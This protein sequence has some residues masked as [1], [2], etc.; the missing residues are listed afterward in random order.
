MFINARSDSSLIR[1]LG[2]FKVLVTLVTLWSFLFSL[3]SCDLAWAIRTPLEPTGVGSNRAGGPGAVIKELNVDTFA[4][5]EY[6]GQVRDSFKANSDKVVIHIQDAHCNYAAQK[7]IAE[8]IDYL[9]KEYGAE[10]INLEGGAQNYDLSIFTNIYDK[11]I[12]D[13]V[14]DYF[15]KEGLVNGA[16]YFAINNPE[17]TTLWGV[18]DNKLY[19]DN[20]NVYRESLKYK[21][22]VDANI[23]T[24]SY[25]INNLKAKIYS[26]DLLELD[27]KYSQY[28]A[29]NLEFKDYLT[30]LVHVAKDKGIDVKSLHNIFL[31]QQ[32]LELESA[33][34]FKSANN[35]RD[36]IID[37]LQKVMSR[38]ELEELVAKT[39]DFKAERLSQKDFYTWLVKKAKSINIDLTNLP[40][41]QKYFVYISTYGVID[42]TKIMEEMNVLEDNIKAAL[43]QNGEQREL[44]KL[45]KTLTLLNNIFNISLTKDDYQYYMDNKESFDVT[46]FTSFINKEAPLYKITAQINQNIAN[47]DQYRESISKF[48]EY[49]FK[50]DNAFL[51]NM[52]FSIGKNIAIV[53][54][55]G[56][57]TENLCDIFRKEK[58]SFISIMPTFKNCDGYECPYFKL[59]SGKEAELVTK[60]YP[61]VAQ[62]SSM[63]ISSML[64]T[65]LGEEVWGVIGVS[66][67]RAAILVREE[68]EKGNNI[69]GIEGKGK[70]IV[71]RIQLTSGEINEVT[72]PREEF[73]R[74]L[75]AEVNI[76]ALLKEAYDSGKVGPIDSQ[77]AGVRTEAA[78]RIRS[79]AEQIG[80]CENADRL[81]AIAD[82]IDGKVPINLVDVNNADFEAHAGGRGIHINR[83][84]IDAISDKEARKEKVIELIV[85]EAIAGIGGAHI[86]A[87]LAGKGKLNEAANLLKN[88]DV[89]LQE[90]AMWELNQEARI[91][92][93]NRDYTANG[94]VTLLGVPIVEFVQTKQCKALF[95]AYFLSINE[96]VQARNILKLSGPIT[97]SFLVNDLHVSDGA[98]LEQLVGNVE[99][100]AMNGQDVA[101]KLREAEMMANSLGKKD[102]DKAAGSILEFISSAKN[103]PGL[104]PSA[105]PANTPAQA[106]APN[107]AAANMTAAI[108]FDGNTVEFQLLLAAWLKAQHSQRTLDIVLS[109]SDWSNSNSTI[110]DAVMS[111][112]GINPTEESRK[113]FVAQVN[114][115]AANG[116]NGKI[117]ANDLREAAQSILAERNGQFR[118]AG[119]NV[120]SM[121]QGGQ[122][123]LPQSTAPPVNA[124][125]RPVQNAEIGNHAQGLDNGLL[126]ARVQQLQEVRGRIEKGDLPDV[127]NFGDKHG[128]NAELE[129]ILEKAEQAAKDGRKLAIVGHGDAFDRGKHNLRNFEILKRLKEIAKNNPNVQVNLCLGNHD[130]MLIQGILLDDDEWLMCWLQNGGSAVVEELR[131]RDTGAAREKACKRTAR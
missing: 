98:K 65:A 94:E 117:T 35:Q 24:L 101:N 51:K 107:A 5:P 46:N 32:T 108:H 6:L 56:F 93:V 53:V 50:R 78:I 106:A 80:V 100:F 115:Q 116:I 19:I 131:I 84:K 68:I 21:E 111:R 39:V 11:S 97:P 55:G 10:V 52:K 130:V 42:K 73:L 29:N 82:Q 114:K 79:L 49:S 83:G 110:I 87:D 15:V 30:Y 36:S 27:T 125:E 60:L 59:L 126:Q 44:N 31:L 96:D 2:P 90:K 122:K 1:R 92:V 85:H 58:V 18:E 63:Q 61:V 118:I 105:R 72:M 28:K 71:F 41:F 91:G 113:E 4:L 112:I 76:D 12:R 109:E 75:H 23:K 13:R 48:Y 66:A 67:F 88:S 104:A 81:R 77:F 120:I 102:Y 124:G 121:L 89:K 33:V 38:N 86:V 14:A 95:A 26:K 128:E 25:I 40:D 57:H 54:T 34:D 20:L 9:N 37:S 64:S 119:R 8:I 43:Y 45:S 17:K 3:V 62:S 16:E 70:D 47:L 103:R 99:A 129:R 7:G 127:I 123:A 69:I 22:E 74:W